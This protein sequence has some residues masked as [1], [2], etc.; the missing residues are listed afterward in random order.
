MPTAWAT[1]GRS[2]ARTS[3]T[4]C[5]SSSPRTTARSAS[6]SPRRWRARC[7][8]SPPS[9]IIDDAITPALPQAATSPADC[10]AAADQLIARVTRRGP[11]R[12]P[13]QRDR[14]SAA[15]RAAASTGRTWRSSSSR[16]AHRRRAAA[17]HARAQAR[18]RSPPAARVGAIALVADVQPAASPPVAGCRRAAV[19][20]GV[21][22]HR[23]RRAAAAAGRGGPMDLGRRRWRRLEA[24]AVA[25]A[26]SAPAAAATSA[27]AAP[28]ETGDGARIALARA[29][30]ST[31]GSTRPTR[32][33]PRRPTRSSGSRQRVAASEQ[34]HSGEIR[35]CRRGRPAAQLPVA[36]RDA[37][38]ARGRAV[39]QARR[40]GHRA[41]QR[42]ADLPAARRARDR[43]R[44]RPRPEPARR[45]GAV[46][47]DRCVD[48]D[49]RSRPA[50]SRP[51]LCARSMRSTRCCV[52]TSRSRRAQPARTNCPIRRCACDACYAGAMNDAALPPPARRHASATTSASARSAS[53]APVGGAARARAPAAEHAV[54]ARCGA[55]A[56][57]ARACS[58]P[59]AL[60]S[61]EEA[62]RRVL[63]LEN[64]GARG[65]SRI[66]QI[67]LRRPAADPARR[68][69]A[70]APAHADRRC[71]SCSR[72][73]AR[74]RRSTAS[75][76]TMRRGDFIITPSWTWH[77][78]G[79][80]GREP[81][82]WLDGLDIPLVHFL[83]A[84]FAEKAAPELA[85][86]DPRAEGMRWPA[87]AT[88]CCR[89]TRAAAPA[90]PTRSSSIRTPQR[91]KRWTASR[92]P[93]RCALRLQAALRQ[94][95]HRPL[96]DA[97]H[98]H[99]CQRAAGR[100]RDAG[101]GAAPTRTVYVCLEGEG[102]AEVDGTARSI[103]RPRRL[104]RA[105]MADILRL[106]ARRDCIL[107]SY[108]DRPVQQA[109][110]LWREERLEGA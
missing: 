49:A 44:R 27:A 53:D 100:L 32:A 97:D 41:Q 110:G 68:G 73:R 16:R 102:T 70:G 25:A 69:G 39:R 92:G 24:A 80:D 38:R 85:G 109:L 2:A 95:G 11:A 26:A 106:Q 20:V 89:W 9:S 104:R 101:P 35:I 71:A 64:P 46:G 47:R 87:M 37:A 51:G 78:H 56:R 94:P 77:D 19:L 4:A 30:C 28:R 33:A 108:S 43:D 23:R 13:T 5:W 66:T 81:V 14:R 62:E 84:G 105:V 79:N 1:P 75:G 59:A 88:T 54:R 31:A 60:I 83:D 99:L 18:A 103:S 93:A 48:A 34:R 72:A 67:S 3:A 6:R 17:R 61:A 21:L 63:I 7:P 57:S 12:A 96:A 65:Q 10:N 86:S 76:T 107:F 58:R 91:A 40:L 22:R 8:T 36:R 50:T 15:R 82:V 52:A 45:A 55:I 98:G 29:C 90:A 42:R 74:T